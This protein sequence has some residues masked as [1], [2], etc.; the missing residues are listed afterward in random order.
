[1]RSATCE[2]CDLVLPMF[3]MREHR[4]QCSCRTELCARCGKYVMNKERVTHACSPTSSSRTDVSLPSGDTDLDRDFDI[5]V[6]LQCMEL[7]SLTASMNTIQNL[8]TTTVWS[9]INQTPRDT[10]EDLAE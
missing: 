6:R 10:P 8:P 4:E 3:M 9:H 7:D 5:A 1:M 2:F